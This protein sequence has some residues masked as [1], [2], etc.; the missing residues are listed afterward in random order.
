MDLSLF[1]NIDPQEIPVLLGKAVV[2]GGEIE[3]PTISSNRRCPIRSIN[4]DSTG[5]MKIELYEDFSTEDERHIKVKLNYRKL[6]FHLTPKQFLVEGK[7]LITTFPMT[8]RALPLREGERYIMPV[9]DQ[10]MSSIY[11][12]ERRGGSCS[13]EACLFDFSTKGLGLVLQNVEEGTLQ[14]HDHIWIK[15]INNIP[16]EHP[17][18]GRVVYLLNQ[19]KSLKVGISLDSG[20]PEDIFKQLQ[21]MSHLVLTA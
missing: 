18:F 16:L 8:A 14:K 2:F 10:V 13:M 9:N 21:M 4:I 20:I 3:Q 11:R 12:I 6:F 17:I 7:T 1:K 19:T 15:S 5:M